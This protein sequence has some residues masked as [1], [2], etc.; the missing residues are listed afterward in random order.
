MPTA[1]FQSSPTLSGGC[2]VSSNCKVARCLPFQSSPTL[3]G[4]C[5]QP[6]MEILERARGFNPHPPF[7]VGATGVGSLLA[8]V[9]RVSILT[10]PFGWVLPQVP[11]RNI[12]TQQVSIL[13]HPFGWVLPRCSSIC[14]RWTP[15]FNPHPPFRVGATRKSAP[16]L[17]GAEEFQSSPTLSGGCYCHSEIFYLNIANLLFSLSVNDENHAFVA[18]TEYAASINANLLFA[19][20]IATGSRHASSGPL[21]SITL[22]IPYSSTRC[23]RPPGIL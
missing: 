3:S 4:G 2:Y 21:K 15:G 18:S 22:L 11:Q 17:P 14:C 12:F 13:T 8:A 19:A 16:G 9:A 6:A 20:S 10:H 5:Y 1:S 7:R 23:S